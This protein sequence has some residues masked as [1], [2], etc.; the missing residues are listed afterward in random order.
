[1]NKISREFS[2]K[3]AWVLSVILRY[4]KDKNSQRVYIPKL[5]FE[6]KDKRIT[7]K[8]ALDIVNIIEAEYGLIKIITHSEPIAPLLNSPLY[9][10]QKKF[11]NEE[12]KDWL[13]KYKSNFEIEVKSTTDLDKLV[14]KISSTQYIGKLSYKEQEEECFLCE[15]KGAIK[16]GNKENKNCKLLKCLFD[17]P[18]AYRS[19][20]SVI[21][22]IRT[23]RDII[24]PRSFKTDKEKADFL[25][26]HAR[27]IQS[28]I[29]KSKEKI[30]T[31]LQFH[32]KDRN[33]WISFGGKYR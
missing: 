32:I 16:I 17:M 12:R 21:D 9:E 27:D 24:K 2:Q 8:E 20:S 28:I 3:I 1:M 23:N 29:K 18:G 7:Q 25:R 10:I 13:E 33:I 6:D 5:E 30:K 11:Y 22:D 15:G 26:N 31:K 19:I 14:K 4:S